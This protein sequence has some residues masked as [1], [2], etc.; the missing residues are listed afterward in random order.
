M[1]PLGRK[2]F[3]N[4]KP[5]KHKIPKSEKPWWEIPADK[6]SDRQEVRIKL[7]KYSEL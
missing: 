3:R 7:N 5:C 6:K 2:M 4:P 1:Q